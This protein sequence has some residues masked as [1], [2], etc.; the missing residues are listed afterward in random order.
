MQ[1]S[2]SREADGFIEP[3]FHIICWQ[4][5][6]ALHLAFWLKFSQLYSISSSVLFTN[7]QVIFVLAFSIIFLKEKTGLVVVAG[8]HCTL[9]GL[10]D[11]AGI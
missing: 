10:H 6:L 4:I 8:I 11:W 1:G 2:N 5:V 9:L 7:L 3:R